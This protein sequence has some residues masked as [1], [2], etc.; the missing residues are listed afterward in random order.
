MSQKSSSNKSCR[1]RLWKWFTFS[2]F[3]SVFLILNTY[4]FFILDGSSLWPDN[5]YGNWWQQMIFFSTWLRPR[6]MRL[7]ETKQKE[8]LVLKLKSF[9]RETTWEELRKQNIHAEDFWLTKIISSKFTIDLSFKE[10]F[11]FI[12]WMSS[13]MWWTELNWTENRQFNSQNLT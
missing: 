12:S 9:E 2:L 3:L 8:L 4:S 10:V 6:L 11:N 7:I 1:F 5:S 13:N